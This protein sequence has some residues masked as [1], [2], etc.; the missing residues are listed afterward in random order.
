MRERPLVERRLAPVRER[1]LPIGV[2]REPR[3]QLSSLQCTIPVHPGKLPVSASGQDRHG[4]TVLGPGRV[5]PP[6]DNPRGAARP[7]YGPP[8]FLNQASQWGLGPLAASHVEC[9]EWLAGRC[10]LLHRHVHT[11]SIQALAPRGTRRR[12]ATRRMA[13]SSLAAPRSRT[14]RKRR[15]ARVSLQNHAASALAGRRRAR[16]RRRR[17]LVPREEVVEGVLEDPGEGDAVTRARLLAALG[18]AREKLDDPIGCESRK[19][20]RGPAAAARARTLVPRGEAAH[21]LRHLRTKV[22]GIGRGRLREAHRTGPGVLPGGAVRARGGCV[23]GEVHE[24]RTRDLIEEAEGGEKHPAL[25]SRIPRRAEGAAELEGSPKGSGGTDSF[26]VLA[27][28]A[29]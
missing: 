5:R 3:H 6:M 15:L 27:H 17:L 24:H 29:E 21:L 9:A 2:R 18:V 16:L 12:F 1:D 8:S 28:E 11:A 4:G 14:A 19:A 7:R 23:F 22:R 25:E 20:D 13:G 10:L 26:A